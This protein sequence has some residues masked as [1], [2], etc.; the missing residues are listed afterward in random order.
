L[1]NANSDYSPASVGG[2]VRSRF[3]A[4]KHKR[5]AQKRDTRITPLLFVERMTMAHLMPTLDNVA[6]S[7]RQL[8][9]PRSKHNRKPTKRSGYEPRSLIN[10][11]QNWRAFMV[12]KRTKRPRHC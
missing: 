11:R 12:N 10:R 5:F 8:Y 2:S 4:V 7:L 9:G 1:Q 3:G 6:L